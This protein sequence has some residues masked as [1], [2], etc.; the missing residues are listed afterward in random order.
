MN[1]V[2]LIGNAT[3]DPKTKT[4]DSGK[5]IANFSI[6]TSEKYKDA[7]GNSKEA[8]EYHDIVAFGRPAEIIAQY[9]AKGQKLMIEGKI[10]TRSW[11]QDGVKKYKTEIHVEKFEFLWKPKG[12]SW[13]DAG[14]VFGWEDL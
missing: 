2:I 9:L 13:D 8:T 3:A 1:K 4:L 5:Q 10:K 11:E 7:Q 6:A 14:D 12:L